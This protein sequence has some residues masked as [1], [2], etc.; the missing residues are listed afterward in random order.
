V[1]F[2]LGARRGGDP[3]TSTSSEASSRPTNHAS[4]TTCQTVLALPFVKAIS[5]TLSIEGFEP[6]S[7]C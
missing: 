5:L 4:V 7:A 3:S 1:S 2:N 6:N